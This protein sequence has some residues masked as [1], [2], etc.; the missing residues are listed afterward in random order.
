MVPASAQ[1]S[2][3]RVTVTAPRIRAVCYG[4][5]CVAALEA[6][7]LEFTKRAAMQEQSLDA[8]DGPSKE[9]IC[10]AIAKTKPR[11][12]KRTRPSVTGFDGVG[13]NGCGSGLFST[14]VASIGGFALL[15]SNYSNNPDEP[16][17]GFSFLAACNAHDACYSQQTAKPTCDN[18]FYA[19]LQGVCGGNSNC[20]LAAAGYNT[21]VRTES[22]NSAYS[23][24]GEQL[25]CY[26]WHKEMDENGCGAQKAE[27]AED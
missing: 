7:A 18:N 13:G 8:N 17:R 25:Q 20:E 9:Q 4:Q 27:V 23:A 19:T 10:Q 26:K 1:T 5:T 3:P 16:V 15:T 6:L 2:L 11:N 24:A 12:C 14:I 22:S 21:A